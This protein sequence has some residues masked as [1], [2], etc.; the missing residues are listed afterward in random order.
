MPW[1]VSLLLVVAAC[2]SP[3][4]GTVTLEPADESAAELLARLDRRCTD[5]VTTD[6]GEG[7]LCAD[8]GFRMGTD[9]F[10]FANWGRSPAADDNI[11]L[12]TMID[13]FGHS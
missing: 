7:T 12:Q 3:G 8:S 10:A 9:G 6:L 4:R 13:L 2:S 1:F 11:S 5:I